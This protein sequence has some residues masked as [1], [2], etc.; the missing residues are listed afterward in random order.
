MKY[1]ELD[2]GTST[3]KLFEKDW[4]ASGQKQTFEAFRRMK[5]RETEVNQNGRQTYEVTINASIRR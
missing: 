1:I 3:H 2:R 5:W 4:K